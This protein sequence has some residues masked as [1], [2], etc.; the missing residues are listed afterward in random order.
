MLK[1]HARKP[2]RQCDIFTLARAAGREPVYQGARTR[3]NFSD[4]DRIP[5]AIAAR[6]IAIFRC[7]RDHARALP[8]LDPASTA[9]QF[10]GLPIIDRLRV[11]TLI[12]TMGVAAIMGFK[13]LLIVAADHRRIACAP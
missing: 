11:L 6:L 10:A 13:P 5:I 4:R 12:R 1:S 7:A 9:E 3:Y 8:T 2:L